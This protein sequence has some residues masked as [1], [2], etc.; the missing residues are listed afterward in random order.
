MTDGEKWF[1]Q[2]SVFF[3][4]V[5]LLGLFNDFCFIWDKFKLFCI[6]Y[7]R[8]PFLTSMITLFIIDKWLI[9]LDQ[10]PQL[11][12][13]QLTYFLLLQCLSFHSETFMRHWN[14]ISR[15]LDYSVKWNQNNTSQNNISCPDTTDTD[16]HSFDCNTHT[17]FKLGA[18]EETCTL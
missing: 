1:T 7:F 14:F 10:Y 5:S 8:L 3:L 11:L 16:F 15:L 17:L 13:M 6:L 12:L 9:Y 4:P 2:Q 18:Q